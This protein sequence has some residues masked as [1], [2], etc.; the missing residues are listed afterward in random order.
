[1]SED[2]HIAQEI[3]EAPLTLEQKIEW[4]VQLFRNAKLGKPMQELII[5][6]INH[7]NN[8]GDPEDYL[9]LP[10]GITFDKKPE[11]KAAQ[12]I[13]QFKVAHYITQENK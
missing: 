9:P 6:A 1:M 11:I 13:D 4:H 7:I 10:E 3:F 8:S 12:V 5:Q 2:K